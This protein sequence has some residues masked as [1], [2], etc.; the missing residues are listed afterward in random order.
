MVT[1]A[2]V[3]RYLWLWLAHAPKWLKLKLIMWKMCSCYFPERTLTT[4]IILHP[5]P[6]AGNGDS[7]TA[8]CC[9]LSTLQTFVLLPVGLCVS[10]TCKI[11]VNTW[12]VL[13]STGI[14]HCGVWPK[15]TDVSEDHGALNFWIKRPNQ[16]VS[17]QSAWLAYSL[18]WKLE[19]VFCSL[20]WM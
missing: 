15:F 16:Q 13:L 6:T 3:L 14:W 17:K 12:S 2:F 1:W 18:T 20:K 9:H 4:T 11:Y 5:K 7:T 19:T 10:I 8:R